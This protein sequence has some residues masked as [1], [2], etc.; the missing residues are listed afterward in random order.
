MRSKAAV[1][2][3]N[4]NGKHLLRECLDS[5]EKQEYENFK[6]IFVD[7]GSSD[8]S[9]EFVKGKY[10]KADVIGLR[11]NTGFAKANNIGMKRALEDAEIKFV[12]ILNNDAMVEKEWLSEMIK[13]AEKDDK[14][15]SIAPKI[16]KYY[17]R[18]V[19]DSVGNA[20]HLDGGG[21]SNHINEVDN[22]QYDDVLELFGPSGCSGLYA[23]SMLEDIEMNGDYFDSDFFAYFEDID[24][25]WRAR[26][27]GWK[28]NFSSKAV[29]YHK[30]SETTGLYSPFKAFY[31]NRNRYFVVIKNFPLNLLPGAFLNLFFG[32]FYSVLS[33]GQNKGPSAR[34]I[35]KSGFWEAIKIIFK[36]WADI[37]LNI[38]KMMEKRIY[39]QRRKVI[40]DK[41]IGEWLIK[42]KL[43]YK[44]VMFDEHA[45]K[46]QR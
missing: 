16:R 17:I 19:L 43:D 6:V 14:I 8:G 1:I 30:H 18:N 31:T 5:V 7:N 4:W 24:L 2:V 3:I 35:E 22:G 32:Y 40:S 23:R 34:F 33:F 15:G 46:T 12:A 10:P 28:C 41:D 26:L 36:G 44:K 27:R 11:E 13:V 45:N 38:P 37:L 20:F 29:V 25:N 21:V 9:I 42:Y 39:I